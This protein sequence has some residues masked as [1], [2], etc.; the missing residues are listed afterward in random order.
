LA[1]RH[2]PAIAGE[3]WGCGEL[4]WRFRSAS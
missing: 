3:S 2:A 4:A 1:H